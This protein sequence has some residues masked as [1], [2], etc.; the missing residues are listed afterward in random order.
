MHDVSSINCKTG[1]GGLYGNKGALLCRFVV[2]DTSLCFVNCHLAAGQ[3]HKLD[4]DNDLV[5]ILEG[6]SSFSNLATSSPGAY[7]VGGDGTAV[8]DHEICFVSGDLNYRI[9]QVREAVV[10]NVGRK[11]WKPLLAQ[12][13]LLKGMANNQSFR[14]RS[15]REA[16]I[17]FAPTYK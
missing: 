8:F 14:L 6:K 5:E 3:R 15:F 16:P 13:Q 4:R 17:T 10:A 11:E 12:D 1:M 7:T 2:D 9:D